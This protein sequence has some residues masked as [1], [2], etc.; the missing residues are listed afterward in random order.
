M[1]IKSGTN[2]AKSIR[3]KPYTEKLKSRQRKPCKGVGNPRCIRSG[4]NNMDSSLVNPK[5]DKK[6]PS[7]M[8]VWRGKNKSKC[9]KSGMGS[10]KPVH[11]KP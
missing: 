2:R 4:T 3:L 10:S 8:Y 7:C 11:I 1:P 9:T 5:A 6:R